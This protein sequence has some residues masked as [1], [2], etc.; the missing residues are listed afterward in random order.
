M[1]RA[2][3]ISLT[4]VGGC[5][6]FGCDDP[7]PACE[8]GDCMADG[9]PPD[10]GA[11]DASVSPDLGTDQGADGGGDAGSPDLGSDQGLDEGLDAGPPDED[12]DTVPDAF[13]NCP[14]VANTDQV[15]TDDDG[16]GDACDDD[17]DDDGVDDTQLSD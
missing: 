8:R 7:P 2:L 9:G 15:D 11:P 1:Q 6:L 17:D 13:D 10:G 16:A 12:A 3:M 14:R 5:A 4:L